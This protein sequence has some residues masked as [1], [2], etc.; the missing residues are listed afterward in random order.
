MLEN[1]VEA[2]F[3]MKP[4]QY[5]QRPLK[6]EGN[7]GDNTLIIPLSY[8]WAS[9]EHADPELR[10][11]KQVVRFL[12]YLIKTRHYKDA[13][14]GRTLGIGDQK[15]LLFLDYMSLP[16]KAGGRTFLDLQ[17]FEACSS[18]QLS[19]VGTW[20]MPGGNAYTYTQHLGAAGK[21]KLNRFIRGGGLYIGTCAGCMTGTSSLFGRR[22]PRP[23]WWSR[24]CL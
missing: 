9:K 24:R 3:S 14:S 22:R 10:T 1:A 17:Q 18:E 21:E 13:R 20:V 7:I 11:I 6:Y 8:C 19:A 12:K 23:T 16:Q 15:P 5:L 4:A 2:G